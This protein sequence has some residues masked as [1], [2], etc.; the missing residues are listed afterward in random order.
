MKLLSNKKYYDL[1]AKIYD[2]EQELIRKNTYINTLKGRCDL[3][4]DLLTRNQQLSSKVSELEPI[5]EKFNHKKNLEKARKKKYMAKLKLNK[6]QTASP[7][8]STNGISEAEE[9][10]R[11]MSSKKRYTTLSKKELDVFQDIEKVSDMF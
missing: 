1:I 10:V 2:Q 8:D 3:V 6:K 4:S 7:A 9:F 5:V 11:L